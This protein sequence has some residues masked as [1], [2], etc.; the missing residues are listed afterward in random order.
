MVYSRIVKTDNPQSSAQIF[1]VGVL[2]AAGAF[3]IWGMVPLYWDQIRSVPSIEIVYHRVAWTFLAAWIVVAARGKLR[4][5]LA[6]AGQRSVIVLTV[7]AGLLVTF[8]WSIFNLSI[9][10][11]R[12]VDSSLGYYINPLFSVFLGTV[13]LKERLTRLQVV[14]LILAAIGVGYLVVWYGEVPWISL[15]LAFTFGLYGLIKK[16]TKTPA[17]IAMALDMSVTAPIAITIIA[18]TGLAGSGAFPNAGARTSLLLAGAGLVTLIPLLL[19]A[20][21]A[22]KI[23]LSNLGFIQYITPTLFFLIGVFLFR[24]DFPIARLPGFVLVWVALIL[25][26]ASNIIAVRRYRAGTPSRSGS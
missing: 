9:V 1:L 7:C 26:T 12:V 11:G 13:F 15:G 4:E 6:L 21:G 8:N 16:Q 2:E 10:I 19:F 25:N 14:A 20:G 23:P 3:A 17:D 24:E 22:R 18:V 5:A